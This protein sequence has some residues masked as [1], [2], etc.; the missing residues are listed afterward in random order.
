MEPYKSLVTENPRLD[1]ESYIANYKGKTRVYRLLHIGSISAPLQ[2]DALR[3]AVI[4]AKAG[5]DVQLYRSAVSQLKRV[6]N[7][8]PEAS[9]DQAWVESTERAVKAETNRLEHE[10]KG[11]KNNLI[12]ES[13]RVSPFSSSW[14]T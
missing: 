6:S 2:A 13:I 14:R 11:Y 4:E 5:K 8:T 10:L 3:A 1:L 9:L 7:S 12:K